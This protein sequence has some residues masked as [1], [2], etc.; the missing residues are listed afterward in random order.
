MSEPGVLELGTGFRDDDVSVLV[1][2]REVWS[3][4]GVTTDYSVGLAAVVPLP[5]TGPGEIEVRVGD[6]ARGTRQV[7]GQAAA[8]PLRLRCDLDPAGAMALGTA[9]EGPVF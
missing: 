5:A 2:G 9:P 7:Q 4:A 1:D 8:G 3:A 6:R